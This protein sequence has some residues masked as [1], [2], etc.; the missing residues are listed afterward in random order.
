[1]HTLKYWVLGLVRNIAWL[2]HPRLPWPLAERLLAR[3]IRR[4]HAS[5][6]WTTAARE[7]MAYLLSDVATDEE[8]DAA[9]RG[10]IDF[11]LLEAELRWHPRRSTN[12][13]IVGVEHL[14]AAH[15]EGRGV[16]LHFAHHG[17]FSGMFGA[18]AK[19]AGLPMQVVAADSAFDWGIGPNLRQHLLVVR[20][21]G[22]LMP[23]S[24]AR[25]AMPRL[26]EDR[27][28]VAIASD[29]PGNSVVRLAGHDVRVSSG[30]IWAARNA[31][32]PI[33]LVDARF[34]ADGP[35]VEVSPAIEPAEHP[36]N[37]ELLQLLVD[38]HADAILAAPEATFAPTAAWP[39]V[40]ADP[41]DQADPADPADPAASTGTDAP[42]GGGARKRLS[43]T[44]ADQAI[45]GGSNVLFSILAAHLL[46]PAGFGYFGVVFLVYTLAVFAVR[47]MVSEPVLIQPDAHTRRPDIL[48]ASI[49]VGAVIG[50]L[51]GLA[52]LGFL[53]VN[54][55]LG[56]ALIALA[57]ALPL[58]ALQDTLRYIGIGEGRPGLAVFVDAAWLG[59]ALLAAAPLALVGQAS[60]WEFVAA[61][62]G[63][64]ALA[65]IVGLIRTTRGRFGAHLGWVR[66][67]WA[68]SWRYLVAGVASQGSA[69]VAISIVGLLAGAPGITLL[70]AAALLNR[71]YSVFQIAATTFGTSEIAKQT[72]RSAIVKVARLLTA[73]TVAAAVVNGAIL[74]SLPDAW[75][76]I[77]LGDS[78]AVAAPAAWAIA[79]QTV[80][81]GLASGA[82]SGLFGMRRVD[83]TV[84]I[85]MLEAALLVTLGGA[86]TAIDGPILGIWFVNL[87]FTATAVLWWRTFGHEASSPSPTESALPAT[88]AA[89]G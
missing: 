45:S 28:I 47:A 20:R 83:R 33:V 44:V 64:G 59:F 89:A 48:G 63:A 3:R 25:E 88:A 77:L 26:L 2:A 68:Y 55:P 60:C 66:R 23:A 14:V 53:A 1:V 52:G 85:T 34:D 49:V 50:V 79:A 40:V 82:R 54:A 13:R 75:G 11:T 38:R 73:L 32:A 5:T 17:L 87:G 10:F 16:V 8:I 30:A 58:L 41:V 72:D 70:A 80:V 35:Y 37:Q 61:W 7:Q 31:N 71:P 42:S 9:A 78:W 57:V 39:R 43:A 6:K 29:A 51:I 69:L 4:A 15:A 22:G 12:Q 56:L 74:V 46:A 36:D 65:G 67:S 19:A 62:G 86:G 76:R 81:M 27:G 18:V 21:G 84:P 24:G